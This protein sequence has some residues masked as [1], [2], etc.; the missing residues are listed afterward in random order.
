MEIKLPLVKLG[1]FVNKTRTNLKMNQV[2]FY[3]YIFPEKDLNDENIKKKMNVIENGK[4]KE[5]NYELLFRL[6]DMFDLSMDYLFGFET[7]YPNYENKA[8]CK[9]TGLLPESVRQLHFWG[10]YLLKEE[11]KYSN[12]MTKGQYKEYLLEKTRIEEAK[13]IFEI[14]NMLFQPK[15]DEDEKSGIS[16]LSVLYDIHMLITDRTEKI[17][18]IPME[19]ASSN[20]S[21]VD[22]SV[23]SIAISPDSLCFSDSMNEIHKVNIIEV[24]RKIWEEQLLKD[25]DALV[26]VVKENRH[27]Q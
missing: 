20:L 13:W 7:E 8:V 26:R 6:H 21:S 24:N 3:R 11:P 18:G 1:D 23:N 12:K 4:G 15:S 2:E 5:M 10:N 16:N 14:V 22:K 25:I 9:Y 27:V 17:V 19:I